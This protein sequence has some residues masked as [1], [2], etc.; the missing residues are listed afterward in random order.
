AKNRRKV[1]GSSAPGAN[2][3][4]QRA[5]EEL[6]AV[7][8]DLSRDGVPYETKGDA[9]AAMKGA[10]RVFR[11]DYR[12][13]YVYHAQMEP[14][15]AT[16]SVSADGKSAEIWAGT[17]GATGLLTQAANLLQ[18]DRAKLTPHQHALG[19]GFGRR[20]P[21]EVVMDALRLSKAVG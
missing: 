15:N 20:G 10:A 16:A 18:T 17:Q 2:H 12:T 9:K 1:T 3:E 19:G 7:G 13:R 14:L 6:A 21:Q 11:G 4:R 5:L 8:R